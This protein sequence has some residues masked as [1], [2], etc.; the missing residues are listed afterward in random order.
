[1][2]LPGHAAGVTYPAQ[3]LLVVA[4]AGLAGE[5]LAVETLALAVDQELERLEAADAVRL[6]QAA[7]PAQKLYLTVLLLNLSLQ[8]T[9]VENKKLFLLTKPIQNATLCCV[10]ID[11][12]AVPS[13]KLNNTNTSTHHLT[14]DGLKGK[15]MR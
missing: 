13:N 1:M 8:F 2:L 12:S 7:L 3:L 14:K 11:Q 15:T 4:A 5:Q 10:S 6:R 9:G